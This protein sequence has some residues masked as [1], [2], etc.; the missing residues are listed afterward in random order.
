MNDRLRRELHRYVVV[1]DVLQAC[2]KGGERG[3]RLPSS[4]AADDQNRAAFSSDRASVYLLQAL[5]RQPPL[6]DMADRARTFPPRQSC[7]VAGPVPR[8]I[9]FRVEDAE[10]SQSDHVQSPT[11]EV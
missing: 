6:E 8:S 4:P 7:S 2:S 5:R 10:G 3:G 9:R 1:S 11:R